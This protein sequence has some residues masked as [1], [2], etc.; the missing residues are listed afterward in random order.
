MIIKAG[1]YRFND[2]LTKPSEQMT[3]NIPFS[4]QSG[5][6]LT[7]I[8][9]SLVSMSNIL[10]LSYTD[11]IE[12]YISPYWGD[13]YGQNI[14]GWKDTIYQFIT[15]TTDTET[16]DI[17]G[18]WFTSNTTMLIKTGTY[19][20]NDDIPSLGQEVIGIPLNYSV[21]ISIDMTTEAPVITA[22]PSFGTSISVRGIS[23]DDAP[24]MTWAIMYNNI[25]GISMPVYA[26]T[27]GGWNYLYNSF[28]VSGIEEPLLLGYGQIITITEDTYTP[29]NFGLWA[30]SNWK[31]YSESKPAV[32]ISYKD[33][34]ITLK[35][36]QTARLHNADDSPFGFT[37]DL[38]IKANGSANCDGCIIEVDTLPTEGDEKALYKMG[39]T[40]YKYSDAFKDILIVQNGVAQSL[41]E[42]Y[43]QMGATLEL[44]YVKTRPTENVKVNSTQTEMYLYYVEDENDILACLSGEIAGSDTNEW[45]S[46]TTSMDATNGGAITDISQATTEGAMYALVE[47]GWERLIPE[48]QAGSP[49]P[50]TEEK[51]IVPSKETQEVVPS[52]ADYL[53]SKVTVKPI[54]ADYIIPSGNVTI[55]GNGDNINVKEFATA[56]VAVPPIPIE[57]ST[58]EEMT[59]LLETAEIGS[60]YKYAGVTGDTYENGRLYIVEAVSS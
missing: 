48:S 30:T 19:R 56:S 45:M 41:V 9:V 36:G 26:P 50:T 57:V 28:V 4:L 11:N 35:A 24:N 5:E 17:T 51:T 2:E 55:T 18:T 1:T 40:Y 53:L 21:P 49:P 25:M 10:N 59:A 58:E 44:Y 22:T 12:A 7:T 27:E 52:Q 46:L 29:T 37:E 60:I 14:K 3:I 43:T 31:P 6:L 20:W 47:Q 42:A 54:P 34:V 16:D 23:F 13:N 15:V 33:K 39:D 38:V 8:Y 32:E